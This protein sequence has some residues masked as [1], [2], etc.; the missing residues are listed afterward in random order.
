[1]H[2]FIRYFEVHKY[3]NLESSDLTMVLKMSMFQVGMMRFGRLLAEDAPSSLIETYQQTSLENVFL[4]LCLSNGDDDERDSKE[5][6]VEL[7]TIVSDVNNDGDTINNS[8]T[9][10]PNAT[11]NQVESSIMKENQVGGAQISFSPS[12][13]EP[14]PSS[15]C[16]DLFKWTRLKAL[17]VKNFIR[18]WRNLGFLVFQFI[19]PTVQ[20]RKLLSCQIKLWPKLIKHLIE[21][22]FSVEK[23]KLLHLSDIS[24]LKMS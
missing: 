3:F 17:L 5:G 21:F 9:T 23:R 10:T 19:I 11:N 13:Y 12:N 20:V 16:Y 6:S 18:M 15:Y 2:L 24:K 7:D 22:C 8:K 1:M 14:S 4:S